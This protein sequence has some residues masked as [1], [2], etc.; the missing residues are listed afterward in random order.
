MELCMSTFD[1]STLEKSLYKAFDVAHVVIKFFSSKGYQNPGRD[2]LSFTAFK[3][4]AET[5]MLI[6]ATQACR[7]HETI[8][9]RIDQLAQRLAL[10][11]RSEAVAAEIALHPSQALKLAVPHIL[12]TKSGFKD[13]NFDNYISTFVDLNAGYAEDCTLSALYEKHWIA[14]VFNDSTPSPDPIHP[15]LDIYLNRPLDIIGCRREDAYGLTHIL[16][17]ATNFGLNPEGLRQNPSFAIHQAHSL[18][19][20]CIETEDYDLACELLLFWPYTGTKMS[21]EADFALNLLHDVE[22]S[23]GHL[24]CSNTD[25]QYILKISGLE[26]ERYVI[27]SS[28]HT[29]YVMGVLAAAMLKQ[30]G[31]AR[32][33][34]EEL[35]PPVPNE[36]FGSALINHMDTNKGHWYPLYQR[37]QPEDQRHL[38][39]LLLDIAI[40][41]AT[42]T[43]DYGCLAGILQLASRANVQ[44]LLSTQAG[45]LLQRLS[46]GYALYN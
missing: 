46:L 20:K 7:E 13:A 24:P 14:S 32:D 8:S 23:V 19:A 2:E 25:P 4:L 28:Y 36:D 29:I 6:Y 44:T 43:S 5:A 33:Q 26:R 12:L 40:T 31:R 18:L 41:Q 3:P 9:L 15:D 1:T 39:R 17:Y 16:M 27:A 34:A 42:I 11:A 38:S 37:Q 35:M 45:G 21:H 30:R 22:S 10:H